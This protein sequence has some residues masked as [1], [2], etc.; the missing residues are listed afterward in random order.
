MIDFIAEIAVYKSLKIHH[1][2]PVEFVCKCGDPN[3]F[4]EGMDH[5]FLKLLQH[6]RNYTSIPMRV[7]SGFRCGFHPIE[8]KKTHPGP[9]TTGRAADFALVGASCHEILYELGWFN[10]TQEDQS[11]R[12]RGI[13]LNQ[14]GDHDDRF[15]HLDVCDAEPWRPRPHVWTY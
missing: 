6:F 5:D 14:K 3:C 8:A 9:H 15:L 11:L 1:F 13:G 7:T 2:D 4:D 10:S 12:F